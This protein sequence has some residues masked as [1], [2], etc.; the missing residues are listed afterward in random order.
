MFKRILL[1]C[2]WKQQCNS[3]LIWWNYKP[4]NNKTLQPCWWLLLAVDVMDKLIQRMQQ[5]SSKSKPKTQ[6]KKTQ[7]HNVFLSHSHKSSTALPCYIGVW[8]HKQHIWIILLTEVS[9]TK[10]FLLHKVEH[11]TQLTILQKS[12]ELF[13]SDSQIMRK[14]ELQTSIRST[15]AD[16][17]TLCKAIIDKL[18][19]PW[20]Q[21]NYTGTPSTGCC[22][23]CVYDA[24]SLTCE[25]K[26]AFARVDVHMCVCCDVYDYQ[27]SYMLSGGCV[28]WCIGPP[29]LR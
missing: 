2:L 8:S 19:M 11:H 29:D 10:L 4:E 24:T 13:H 16:T 7:I 15:R 26:K 9:V 22:M 14:R 5:W 18:Y 28:A 25:I 3:H 27:C 17:C 20:F 21:S 23:L 6:K 1:N 12:F